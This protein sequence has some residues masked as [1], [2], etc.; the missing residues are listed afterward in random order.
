M[1]HERP[2]AI[3]IDDIPDHVPTNVFVQVVNQQGHTETIRYDIFVAGL[4]K[5]QIP[6]MMKAHAALG[7][8]GEAGE[9]ADAIKKDCIYGKK[10]D[11]DNIVEELG[12]CRF[13]MRALMNLY[14]ISDQEVDQ[15]N[16]NKLAK[17]YKG[18]TY[19]DQAAIDRADKQK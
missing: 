4:F 14:G 11:R 2:N 5:Q 15:G 16:A 10:P 19:S 7:L 1:M 6:A 18:L 3:I 8:C 9:L 17:R 13:Y 12:D